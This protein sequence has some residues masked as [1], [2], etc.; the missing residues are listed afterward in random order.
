MFRNPP[1][2]S[3]TDI[4]DHDLWSSIRVSPHCCNKELLKSAINHGLA[5]RKAKAYQALAEYHRESMA[6]EWLYQQSEA[7][8]CP[9]PRPALLRQTLSHK[10]NCWHK[11]TIQFGKKIDWNPPGLSTVDGFHYFGFFAPVVNAYL[12]TGH[13]RYA[14]FI[15]DIVVQ[16]KEYQNGKN[17]TPWYKLIVYN[18]L[19]ASAKLRS[20][21][22]A[23]L[24]LIHNNQ[25]TTK[26]SESFIKHFL[27]FGR[28]MRLSSRTFVAHNI[29]THGCRCLLTL[30]RLFP[31]FKEAS[32]W[33]K[34]G[35]LRICQQATRGYHPDGCHDERVWGYSSATLSSIA[36]SYKLAKRYGG[37]GDKDKVVLKGIRNAYRFFAKTVGPAPE[38]GQPTYG[39]SGQGSFANIL[40]A[41]QQFFPEG[42]GLDLGIDRT[43]SCIF[44]PSGFA[45]MRNGDDKRSSYI[46][47]SF[48]KYAGWHSH[49]D[50]LGMNFWAYGKPLLEELGRFAP[51]AMPLDTLFRSPEAHNLLTIDG[52]VYNAQNI[53][54]EDVSWYS[55]DTVDYFSATHWAYHYFC[56]GRGERADNSPN[57]EAKVRRTILFVKDP[58][59]AIVM[60]SVI[61][62]FSGKPFKDA[63][64]QNWHSPFPFTRIGPQSVA[65]RG[66][67]GCVL[68]FAHAEG[69]AR[70]DRSTD[71]TK[72]E[73]EVWGV[74]YDRHALKARRWMGLNHQGTAG[75]TTLIYP[76]RGKRP[77]VSI[78][79]TGTDPDNFWRDESLE[80][81]TP[82]GIDKIHLSPERRT[83]RDKRPRATVSL[84]H[85]RGS[86]TIA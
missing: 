72:G 63:I 66:K 31:E 73:G 5:G 59:Y 60:D 20:W 4:S 77:D 13:K 23:Y 37:L 15:K 35:T 74:A 69:L 70:L 18:Q 1:P 43:E 14:D 2:K 6:D 41:G 57:T 61:D 84:A 12:Q 16:Y 68:S 10:I 51:Y 27:G 82:H 81:V 79:A 36:E 28:M 8:S 83:G 85:R 26:A 53:R 44:K 78:R 30:G 25:L 32:A 65:T 67:V 62:R 38:Y 50:L 45:I 21:L 49:Q 54:A 56:Y 71:F 75:F 33:D 11:E 39:D 46:N 86:V 7:M 17:W 3:V 34:L 19:A 76:Y 29:A 64:T 58:G 9:A 42:T 47:L 48:G 55:D 52:M 80:V 40:K 22:P 24:G